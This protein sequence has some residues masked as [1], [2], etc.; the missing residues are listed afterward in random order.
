MQDVVNLV[1]DEA[2][3]AW[4]YRWHA[5][6]VAWAVC[7]LG[8][9]WV[10][11]TP[12]TY[13][14]RA[15]FYLDATSA[16]E[17]F[18]KNLSVGIDVDQ[19]VDLVRQVILG[20]EALLKVA[21]ETDLD[22]KA[23]TPDELDGLVASLRERISLEGGGPGMRS[24]QRDRN[25]SIAYRDSDRERAVKVVRIV[26]DSFIEN[27]LQKRS[28]GF[29]S[30]QD[31]LQR[32]I[33]E[34]EQRLTEA[35]QKLADFKRRN[36]NN[37]PTQEGSYV[38][39]LQAEMAALQDLQ[40]QQRVLQS[41]RSQLSAQLAA[42]EQYVPSSS[43]P[44]T[45]T[46]GGQGL[47]G[48]SD[49]DRAILEMQTR[50]DQ[51]L[52]VY[53]PKHPEVVALEES[54]ALMR[55]QRREEL[56]KMGVTDLPERGGMVANPVWE[57]IRLQRNQVDVE[58]AAVGGQVAERAA[59]V[60]DM[61]SKMETM[62]EVEAE[63]A[64]LTRDYDVLRDRY[65]ALLQQF[66][67]AKLSESVGETDKVEFAI[68]DPPTSLPE[69]VAPPRLLLLL[70]VLAAGLGA[71]AGVAFLLSKLNPVF[72][73]LTSLETLTGLPVLGAVSV[74]WLDRRRARRRSELLRVASAG[75]ALLVVFVVVL[76]AR[77]AG[78]RL[79]TGLMS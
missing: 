63:L 49:T 41:R 53:T 61:R 47:V 50:L 1:R 72:D 38:T 64:Q 68:I 65:A 26:L 46:T 28:S 67:T 16:L 39:S 23:T 40:S 11:L 48:G 25:F 31:F 14:A 42:E 75:A 32:Q 52:R 19:Q 34:Q 45:V 5:V 78:S 70:G 77:D 10:Y 44:A 30:A 54:L 56:A 59:R 74:T 79:L 73:S 2:R 22:V 12:D 17:P 43:L 55:A 20:R 57:Q 66:E 7:V 15:R 62:P 60:R 76:I 51:L 35:E 21:R 33:V 27:T 29:Q 36:I 69:P 18:V 6:A 37:L 24:G 71:G 4:R 3:A 58:L 9:L 8:W 13:E